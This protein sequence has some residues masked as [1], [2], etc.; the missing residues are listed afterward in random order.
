MAPKWDD[1]ADFDG[2]ASGVVDLHTAD[3]TTLH[4]DGGRRGLRYIGFA[5]REAGFQVAH[6][7]LGCDTALAFDPSAATTTLTIS[8]NGFVTRL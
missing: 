2:Q 7:R 8:A 1:G 4:G 5:R 3:G 6:Q